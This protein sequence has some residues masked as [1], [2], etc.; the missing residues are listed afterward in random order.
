MTL[1]GAGAASLPIWTL[2]LAALYVW[3]KV[4]CGTSE[5]FTQAEATT[6]LALWKNRNGE[7]R[8]S[9]DDGFLK[10]N[11]LREAIGLPSLTHGEYAKA[12]D[13]LVS[14]SCIE[15]TDGIIWL[16]EWIRV[17]YGA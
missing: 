6:I 15:L 16:R 10:T 4:W 14:I 17:K 11:A 13:H 8:I 2:P 3:N 1:A 5:E 12:I 9:D 7:N